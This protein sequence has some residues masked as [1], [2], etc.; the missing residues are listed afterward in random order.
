MMTG[1]PESLRRTLDDAVREAVSGKP[2]AVAF[3]GGLDSGI[4]AAVV[5]KYAKEHTLYTVG[6]TGSHDVKEAAS[7][8]E[9]LG[10]RWVRIPISEDDVL[11]GLKEMISVTGTRDPVTLSFEIPLFFV[12]KNCTEEEVIGGQGADELFAGYSKYIG[13]SEEDLKNRMAED[14]R[15]LTEHTLPHEKKVAEHFGKKMHYP[16]LDGKVMEAAGRLEFGAVAPAG[17]PVS[18]KRVLRDVSDLFGYPNIS[19]KEKKAAQYGSGTM[20]LI[21]KICKDKGVTYAELI[22]MLCRE[23]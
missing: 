18:R 13:L 19:A 21:R 11:E 22:E 5:K 16:F 4:V 2:V 14:M 20:A 8:A 10:M 6:S 1:G 15:K 17:D 9:E 3:S 7:A 23:V 12:C